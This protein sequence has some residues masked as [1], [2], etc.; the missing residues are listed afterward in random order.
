MSNP[1]VRI[2]GHVTDVFG[3][4]LPVGVDHDGLTLGDFV[5]GPEVRDNFMKLLMQ[6]DTEAKA[7]GEAQAREADGEAGDGG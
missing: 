1:E 7:W 6:A 5:L 3:R 2:L 4:N